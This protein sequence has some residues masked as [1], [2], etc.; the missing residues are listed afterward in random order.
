[1]DWDQRS[2][3]VAPDHQLLSLYVQKMARRYDPAL[4]LIRKYITPQP[5]VLTTRFHW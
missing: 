3:D 5:I 1:L 4:V 2:D